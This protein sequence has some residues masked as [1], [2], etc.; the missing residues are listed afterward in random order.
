MN[1]YREKMI[2]FLN[3]VLKDELSASIFYM[4]ASN[5]LVGSEV[6]GVSKELAV[7]SAEEMAHFNSLLAYATNHG[8]IDDIN[9][10]LDQ[11]VIMFSPLNDAEKVM[12]K[13][14]ELEKIAIGDYNKSAMCAM[15]NSDLESHGFFKKLMDDEIGHFD[16]LAYV[17]GDVRPLSGLSS[18]HTQ[19][20]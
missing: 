17:N 18:L 20:M 10:E 14:Q 8:L 3:K 2:A 6:D 12:R 19:I 1:D 16:D 7:H 9:I 15:K 13:V 5:E 11:S 4:K